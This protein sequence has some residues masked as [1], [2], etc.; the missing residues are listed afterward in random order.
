MRKLKYK[1][2]IQQRWL[3]HRNLKLLRFKKQKWNF[4][5]KS[6]L[7]KNIDSINLDKG[8]LQPSNISPKFPT[9]IRRRFLYKNKLALS[10][11][12]R[13]DNLSIKKYQLKSLFYKKKLYSK[14]EFF[15]ARLNSRLDTILVKT[16]LF[17]SL[18]SLNQFLKH[19][20][21]FINNKLV[22]EGNYILKE[23]DIISFNPEKLDYYKN[24]FKKFYP[25]QTKELNNILEIN[26]DIFTFIVKDLDKSTILY[27]NYNKFS[28]ELFWSGRIF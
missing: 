13:Y 24:L 19:E 7:G 15:L 18:A 14:Y 28:D 12:L 4:I 1:A 3:V 5:K 8:Q 16:G 25:I 11:R 27:T 22:F 9:V 26:Y 23:G 2:C 20:G 6:L 17:S 21:V 10:K